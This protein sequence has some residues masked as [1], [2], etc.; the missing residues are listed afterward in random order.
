MSK[1]TPVT[2]VTK[3]WKFEYKIIISQ[4]ACDAV[5]YTHDRK[6]DCSQLVRTPPCIAPSRVTQE[7]FA[8]LVD[9]VHHAVLTPCF[10]LVS[11]FTFI[12]AVLRS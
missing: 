10:K 9:R 7:I 1:P 3:V 8:V 2:M 11:F 5:P 6:V 12:F 4:L